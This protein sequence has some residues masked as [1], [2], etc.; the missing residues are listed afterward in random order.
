MQNSISF[1]AILPKW[2]TCKCS[3]S[4]DCFQIAIKVKVSTCLLWSTSYFG[5]TSIVLFSHM[6]PQDFQTVAYF[7]TSFVNMWWRLADKFHTF[8]RRMSPESWSL[9][10]GSAGALRSDSTTVAE[11]SVT[12]NTPILSIFKGS[13]AQKIR[14]WSPKMRAPSS[15]LQFQATTHACRCHSF[16][17]TTFDVSL[18]L[19]IQL[20][21]GKHRHRILD[22]VCSLKL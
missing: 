6:G 8:P 12:A 21:N 10:R 9:C 19:Q 22:T 2:S 15:Q 7:N 4:T 3:I 17:D 14:M 18:Y 20:L 11:D 13:K 1:S 16:Q 5:I